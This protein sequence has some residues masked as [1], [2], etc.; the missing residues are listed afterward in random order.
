MQHTQEPVC[1]VIP[2]YNEED[3][4]GTVLD[5]LINVEDLA[6]ILVV[7]DGSADATSQIVRQYAQQDA[8]VNLLCLAQN[9]GK[10]G[11]MVAGAETVEQ[12][13]VLFLDADLKGLRPEHVRALCAPVCW[14]ECDMTLGLFT[15]G[16]RQTDWSH[17]LTPFLSGQRCLRWSLYRDAPELGQARWGVEVALS[18]YAWHHQHTV[19]KIFWPGVTHAMRMEKQHGLGGYWSHLKMWLDIGR[20]FSRYFLFQS[21]LGQ[22][23]NEM[24]M[25]ARL[26]QSARKRSKRRQSLP[27]RSSH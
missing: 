26:P 15:Q 27:V 4:I 19:Q 6:Q 16:R 20:Y 1:A 11:A 14:G 23:R 9:L 18:L 3:Y 5:V 10:G 21:L 8:R 13:L 7:D 17:R 12:D 2:A 24:S 22:G 25:P